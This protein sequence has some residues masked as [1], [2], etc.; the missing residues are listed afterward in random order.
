MSLSKFLV[1]GAHVVLEDGPGQLEVFVEL[2]DPQRGA[3]QRVGHVAEGHQPAGGGVQP[4]V[5]RQA[6]ARRHARRQ[7][8]R[9][10]SAQAQGVE[11]VRLPA[12]PQRQQAPCPKHHVGVGHVFGFQAAA[13]KGPGVAELPR[14]QGFSRAPLFL[15]ALQKKTMLRRYVA[16][17]K[18]SKR[19]RKEKD[20][21]GC[22][23]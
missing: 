1:T 3:R 21:G 13:P 8:R 14:V 22:L 7:V 6:L 9:A 5:R 20:Y 10:R 23:Q 15:K 12:F 2:E 18:K 4:R 11:L 16:Y 17:K 19:N